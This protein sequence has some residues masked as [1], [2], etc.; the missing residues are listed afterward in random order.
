MACPSVYETICENQVKI[1]SREWICERNPLVCKPHSTNSEV[2][3]EIAVHE[4]HRLLT[5]S[6]PLLPLLSQMAIHG[7][8]GYA[9]GTWCSIGND[10]L[11]GTKVATESASPTTTGVWKCVSAGPDAHVPVRIDPVSGRVQCMSKNA[12]DCW[13]TNDLS[14][15]TQSRAPNAN[16]PGIQPASCTAAAEANPAGWCGMGLA[17][18]K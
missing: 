6:P 5:L 3:S 9:P 14:V 17:L 10:T 1:I 8:T 12:R 2:F 18:F 7:T 16:N 13:W 15:C 11:P 4:K